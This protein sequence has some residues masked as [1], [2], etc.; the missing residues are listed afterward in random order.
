VSGV[1]A[2]ITQGADGNMWVALSSA[3]AIVRLLTGQVPISTQVPVIT[4]ATAP[5]AGTQLSASNGSWDYVPSAYTYQWQSCTGSTT[6]VSAATCTN[7]A[8]ASAATYT[9]TTNDVG[10]GLRVLVTARNLNGVGA[11]STSALVSVGAPTPTPTPTPTPAPT[12]VGPLGPTASIG[13]NESADLVIPKRSKRRV[14]KNYTV[15][16]STTAV[17]GTVDFVFK[18]K[19]RTRTV[20]GVLVRNGVATTRWRVPKNWP[21]A[22]V[23]VTATFKPAAGSPYTTASVQGRV[24]VPNR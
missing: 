1:P 15:E 6:D 19:K 18:R 23:V 20:T 16:F 24:R 2:G 21:K 3:S 13:S 11:V 12:P 7:I 4:P 10:K 9:T 8:G 17:A 22:S 14:A 5:G